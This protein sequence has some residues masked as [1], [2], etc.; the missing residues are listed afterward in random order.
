VVGSCSTSSDE[1]DSHA[2]MLFNGSKRWEMSRE[3]YVL[4]QDGQMYPR[5]PTSYPRSSVD[6]SW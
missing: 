3:S 5:C 6:W 4:P 1:Q 2:K